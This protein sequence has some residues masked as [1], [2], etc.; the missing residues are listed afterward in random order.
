MTTAVSSRYGRLIAARDREYLS[1]R[2]NDGPAVLLRPTDGGNAVVNTRHV[3]RRS[4]VSPWEV[5]DDDR[6]GTQGGV[7]ERRARPSQCPRRDGRA[8]RWPQP[9]LPGRGQGPGEVRD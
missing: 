3:V 1:C 5:S 4:L 2:A 7:G 6:S 8:L 9:V